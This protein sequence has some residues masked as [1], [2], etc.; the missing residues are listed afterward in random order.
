[1]KT[2]N[3]NNT[4]TKVLRLNNDYYITS[5]DSITTKDFHGLKLSRSVIK[6]PSFKT[7]L[8]KILNPTQEFTSKLS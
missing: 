1:M 6:H 5:W 7:P 3:Y 8:S 4:T 2:L